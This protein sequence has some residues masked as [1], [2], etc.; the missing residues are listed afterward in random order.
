MWD[1]VVAG[2]GPAGSIAAAWL[3]RAGARVLVVDRARFP[4]DKLC[5]DSLNP[6]TVTRLG[7]LHPGIW[8]GPN[9]LAG[10]PIDGMLVTGPFGVRIEGRYPRGLQG[11]VL[12]R[13]DLDRWLLDAAIRAGA[14]FDDHVVV[15]RALVDESERVAPRARVRG[16]AVRARDGRDLELPARV[17]I[18]AD[19]RRS[20]LAS[21]LGLAAPGV[22]PA[23]W[24]VGAYF[25]GVAG[26]TTLGEM[27]I[28]THGY[29][30]VAPLAGGLTNACLVAPRA[31][32]ERAGG[33]ARALRRFLAGDRTLG[34]RFAGARM[35]TPPAILGPLGVEARAAGVPGL[36]LAGDA[37]GFIDP[38]TGDGLRF[39]TEGGELA[40]AV[41]LDWLEGRLVG[42]HVELARRR[43]A[44]FAGKWRLNRTLRSLVAHPA[45]LA[46]AA[47]AAAVVPAAVRILV[48]AAG[49]C[50]GAGPTKEG[51]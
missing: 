23:R 49:D 10:A 28:R 48:A 32:I 5:G 34:P 46:T 51:E 39:A 31:A 42:E 18:A 37:A 43:R 21:A 29:V 16:V 22:A 36:L 50:R 8:T 17:T 1:A 14:Q 11:R 40:A 20:V 47:H 26:T 4:R 38:M 7:R 13:R 35:T 25:E 19:G 45:A 2:A 27:H 30:G 15:R 6:G 24:A 12:L 33:P 41:A 44:A 3:A 9:S